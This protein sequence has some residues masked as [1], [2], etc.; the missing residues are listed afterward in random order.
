MKQKTPSPAAGKR[1]V[2]PT[3][4]L[5]ALTRLEPDLVDRIFDYAVALMPALAGQRQQISEA[6]RAEFAGARVYIRRRAEQPVDKLAQEVLRLFKGRNA[7]E[8]ART[9]RI[10]RA[11]VYRKL[12]QPGPKP[13]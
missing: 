10:G 9:L 11:T 5:D 1:A 13:E 3:P 8:V 2:S 12:K 6:L 7:S 4:R